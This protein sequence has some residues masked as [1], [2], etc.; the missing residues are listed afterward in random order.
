MSGFIRVIADPRTWLWALYAI[1]NILIIVLYRHWRARNRFSLLRLLGCFLLSIS[2]FVSIFASFVFFSR[3]T[4]RESKVDVSPIEGLT[5]EQIGRL[6]DVLERFQGSDFITKP[7]AED[8]AFFGSHLTNIYD[9]YWNSPD[10]GAGL[11][12]TIDFYKDEQRA[13][14]VMQF[15]VDL[16]NENNGGRHKYIVFDNNTEAILGHSRMDTTAD[17]LYFPTSSR[18]FSSGIRLGNAHISLVEY[19]EFYNQDKNYSSEFIKLLCEMLAESRHGHNYEKSGNMQIQDLTISMG[20]KI[21][22]Q[23]HNSY[24][25]D[26][27]IIRTNDKPFTRFEQVYDLESWKRKARYRKLPFADFDLDDDDFQDKYLAV[28]FNREVLEME[29]IGVNYNTK[30]IEV[31]ITYDEEYHANTMFL[32]IMDKVSLRDSEGSKF[33]QMKG[34]ERVFVGHDEYEYEYE[35]E[36]ENHK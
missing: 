7:T 1:G 27:T 13:K 9:M 21:D 36:D 29:A 31:A 3:D 22:F 28:S 30:S 12:I 24:A 6:E 15:G 2:V 20:D 5:G 14:S 10:P 16:S 4:Y 8:K 19:Q 25:I 17:S 35:D 26:T 18:S 33:Y 32:Y 23:L 34:K 11:M